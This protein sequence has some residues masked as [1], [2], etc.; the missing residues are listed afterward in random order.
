MLKTPINEW[1]LINE[2]GATVVQLTPTS[3]DW[4]RR[5]IYAGAIGVYDTSLNYA[6]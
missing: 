1:P 5:E 2:D 3:T 6:S 4:A